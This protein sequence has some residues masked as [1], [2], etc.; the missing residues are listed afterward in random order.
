[1]PVNL[2]H[3]ELL[4]HR[5]NARPARPAERSGSPE[6]AKRDVTEV[7]ANEARDDL[8]VATGLSGPALTLVL[9]ASFMVVLDFS[10]VNVALPAI[11]QA[12]GFGGDSVQWVVTAYAITFG[13]LLVL[14]GRMADILGR[15]KMFVVGLIVFAVASLAAGLTGDAVLLVV[16]RSLQGLG[17]ALVA[18]ASLSLITAHYAEGPRRTLALG[19]YGATA[20]VG[21][22]AGQVFGGVLVEY[23]TWRSIFLVNVPVGLAVAMLASVLLAH[24]RAPSE[25][26]H[27][28]VNG[29]ILSTLVVA[30]LVFGLSEG[31][32][33][34]WG[35]PIVIGALVVAV[36]AATVFE[37]VERTSPQPLIDLRMLRRPSLAT[38]GILA[39]LVGMWSAGE[40]VVLSLYLQ[41]SLND[42]PLVTGLVIAPQGV[43]GFVTG[44]F[45]ARLVRRFGMRRLLMSATALTGVGF[46]VLMNLP[47]SGHYSLLFAAVVPVGFGTVGAAFGSTVLA[48]SGMADSD[49]GLV[50][51]VVNTARQIGAAIGVALLVAIADS[52]GAGNGLATI[53]G[54]RRAISA[55]AAIA[56][57]GTVVVWF[58]TKTTRPI[59][60]PEVTVLPTSPNRYPI[61]G[62]LRITHIHRS[63][64]RTA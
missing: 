53:G 62:S 40:L 21:F 54:D 32:L 44:M 7:R 5:F 37:I 41:Q 45:G 42:S 1:M 9:L 57:L 30:A 16:A 43:I 2:S 39:M 10:I 14:G 34:G 48:A 56:L 49:Q 24:D 31:S 58:G 20:S 47:V 12:L 19:L 63:I 6:T 50:G 29:G 64:R 8:P 4:S 46:L 36:V 3:S 28:D 15:R 51:G 22:V 27:L 13:G 35:H 59:G 23:T 61:R 33:L 55:A 52:A 60:L 18:P 11:R 17:A 25:R 38:A 26:V